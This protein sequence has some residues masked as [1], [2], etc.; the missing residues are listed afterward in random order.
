MTPP[1]VVD[2]VFATKLAT[3]TT[4]TVIALLLLPVTAGLLATTRIR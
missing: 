4:F 3:G 1:V 2:I